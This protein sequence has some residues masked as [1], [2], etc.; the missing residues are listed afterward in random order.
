VKNAG[1]LE[2]HKGRIEIKNALENGTG[3]TSRFSKTLS[4]TTWYYAIRLKN[5]DVLRVSKTTSSI[6]FVFANTIPL[7][8]IITILVLAVVY[9]ASKNLTKR[10]VKPLN[11]FEFNENSDTK[12]LILPYEELTPFAR[13]IQEQH[14]KINR[15]IK[16]IAKR[17]A[18]IFAITENMS[19]GVIL[20]SQNKEIISLNHTIREIFNIKTDVIKHY[21][22]EIIRD[23]KIL[24]SVEKSL[25]G[26]RSEVIIEKNKRFFAV[27]L[28]PVS[29]IGAIAVFVDITEKKQAEKLRRE[30]TANVS[31][32][33]KTPLTSIS[34]YSE[35]L[36]NGLV[37][38]E[39]KPEF[40]AKIYAESGRMLTLID[41]IMF[42]SKLDESER[43]RAENF[44]EVDL[45]KTAKNAVKQLENKATENEISLEI[46]GENRVVKGIS[47]MLNDL[48]V[49]LIDNGIKYNNPGGSVTIEICENCV[50]F[51][52][53]GIGIPENSLEHIFDRFY[54]V[55]K[56]RSKKTGGTGL[57]LAISKHIALVHSAE[58]TVESNFGAGS[59]FTVWI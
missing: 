8:L 37:K 34:G 13:K 41:D 18:T 48:F 2:N 5:G 27:Y 21:L 20:I 24:K 35:L 51:I 36:L 55:D 26:E 4:E 11:S 45:L 40:L 12:N 39:D 29:E 16:K 57:G 42:L 7:I 56:S 1:I 9:F 32:E 33:L 43:I 52:D 23:E 47:S 19:E 3:E 22:L 38:D 50:K 31:H 53:T 14:S 28:S 59:T 54:R 25:N 30:F 46:K 15:Q 6:F 58:I 44:A 17:N 49:N 10:I